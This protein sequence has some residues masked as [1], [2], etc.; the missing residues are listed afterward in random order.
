MV[1]S[2]IAIPVIASTADIAISDIALPTTS[3]P[4]TEVYLSEFLYRIIYSF[5][6]L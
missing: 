2:V 1:Y 5:Y 6:Y 3:A 4:S